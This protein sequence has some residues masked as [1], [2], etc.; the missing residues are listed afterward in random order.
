MNSAESSC[1]LTNY[2]LLLDDATLFVF[3]SHCLDAGSCS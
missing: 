2:N 3:V 1:K